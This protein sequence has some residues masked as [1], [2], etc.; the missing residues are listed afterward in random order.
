[1]SI[2]R[3]I[4]S[5]KKNVSIKKAKS[6]KQRKSIDINKFNKSKATAYDEKHVKKSMKKNLVHVYLVENRIENHDFRVTNYLEFSNIAHFRIFVDKIQFIFEKWT[7]IRDEI[8]DFFSYQNVDLFEWLND[9]QK[10][11]DIDVKKNLLIINFEKQKFFV[12][13][14]LCS[15][16]QLL[17]FDEKI[18]RNTMSKNEIHYHDFISEDWYRAFC[19]FKWY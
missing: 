10:F 13:T 11:N 16:Y 1:M 3:K 5:S 15:M 14:I 12:T 4:T 19:L 17:K 18:D 7:K 6:S 9:T 2:K 8:N